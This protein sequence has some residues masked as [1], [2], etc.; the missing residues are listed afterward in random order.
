M[1]STFSGTIRQ[2]QIQAAHAYDTNLAH[3]EI[4]KGNATIK[5]LSDELRRIRPLS[6]EMK[7][8]RDYENYNPI[9]VM[10]N[11]ILDQ[12]E[13]DWRPS[14]EDDVNNP[15]D[16]EQDWVLSTK[17]KRNKNLYLIALAECLLNSTAGNDALRRWSAHTL[18][19]LLSGKTVDPDFLQKLADS[20]RGSNDSHTPTMGIKERINERII[21]LKKQVKYDGNGTIPLVDS[22]PNFRKDTT[23]IEYAQTHGI[24]TPSNITTKNE[25][26]TELDKWKELKQIM[27]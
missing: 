12:A 19:L 27:I 20:N 1:N 2:K 16:N 6:E 9:I 18:D 3:N 22:I 23:L 24:E 26:I 17:G 5:N 15:Y 11:C 7:A 25:K 4:H 8:I 14:Y 21:M 13:V 10:Q